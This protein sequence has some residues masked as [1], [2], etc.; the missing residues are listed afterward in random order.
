MFYNFE[1]LQDAKDFLKNLE[2]SVSKYKVCFIGLADYYQADKTYYPIWD[3]L[4]NY[5]SKYK[6]KFDSK[7]NDNRLDVYFNECH[8]I[9]PDNIQIDVTTG[10]MKDFDYAFEFY[11]GNFDTEKH[12]NLKHTKAND[13]FI[14]VIISFNEQYVRIDCMNIFNRIEKRYLSL[15]ERIERKEKN[16]GN[17]K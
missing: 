1:T 4:A 10:R 16:N 14:N 2:S 13:S 17:Q 8:K 5:I 7:W 12:F 6:Q 15:E 3:N 9:T 11:S